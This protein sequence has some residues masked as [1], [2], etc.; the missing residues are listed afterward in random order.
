MV[1]LGAP[2]AT[3]R[4]SLNIMR[5]YLLWL[6]IDKI[7]PM[8]CSVWSM[9]SKQWRWVSGLALIA[10]R[11][12]VGGLICEYTICLYWVL[13]HKVEWRKHLICSFSV[14]NHSR[15]EWPAWK[16][17]NGLF[18]VNWSIFRTPCSINGWPCQSIFNQ[19]M[20]SSR[21]S[22]RSLASELKFTYI[23]ASVITFQKT[24]RT[25]GAIGIHPLNR[26]EGNLLTLCSVSSKWSYHQ[27]K[28]PCASG[29]NVHLWQISPGVSIFRNNPSRPH[30]LSPRRQTLTN[31]PP[32]KS[33]NS[34]LT[35]FT[36]F[37]MQLIKVDQKKLGFRRKIPTSTAT[38]LQ[39]L[40]LTWTLKEKR[41]TQMPV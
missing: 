12:S 31:Q 19:A 35:P 11:D 28:M 2:S 18:L 3:R 5:F 38:W 14:L 4:G 16:L 10:Y 26:H 15:G 34:I 27:T 21:T 9:A 32:N 20:S 36:S 13:D 29:R 25:P 7:F 17:N 30:H 40:I 37:P 23:F 33:L 22:R 8:R 6:L 41:Y 24:V 39:M 1:S